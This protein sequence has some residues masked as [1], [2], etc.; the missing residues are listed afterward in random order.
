MFTWKDEEKSSKDDAKSDECK[1]NNHAPFLARRRERKSEV[2]K[3]L[4]GE[5][6]FLNLIN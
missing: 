5:L 1:Y 4:N 3:F 6:V 2:T